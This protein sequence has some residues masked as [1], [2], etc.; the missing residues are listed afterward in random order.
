MVGGSLRSARR[1]HGGERQTWPRTALA[2]CRRIKISLER[3]RL[4]HRDQ[5][6]DTSSRQNQLR[7]KTHTKRGRSKGAHQ[8]SQGTRM[9]WRACQPSLAEARAGD[10]FQRLRVL[11]LR[12]SRCSPPAIQGHT[13]AEHTRTRSYSPTSPLFW[14]SSA[15]SR[16]MPGFSG[17]SA[18]ARLQK[19][20]ASE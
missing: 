11:S 14:S 16:R 7:T 19:R 5:I 12:H 8:R 6:I 20:R 13:Q 4:K 15:I 1:G 3:A 18:R 17:A 9:D 2:S 10:I